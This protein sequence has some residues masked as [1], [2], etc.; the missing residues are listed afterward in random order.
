MMLASASAMAQTS[1][2]AST[3]VYDFTGYSA[4]VIFP[5]FKKALDEGRKYPTDRE[6][7]AAGIN[8]M[9][10]H[11]VRSHVRP[12]SIMLDHTKDIN[13]DVYPGRKLWMNIP[14]GIGKIQG[15]YPNVNVSDDTFTGWNYTNIFGSW[16]QPFFR[17]PAV[18]IDTAHKNGTDIYSGIMFFDTTGGRGQGSGDYLD[19]ISRKNA[20]GTFAYVEPIINALMYFGS[21]GINYN[22]EA[23]GYDNADVIKFHQALYKEAERQGFDNFHIGLYT[24]VSQLTNSNCEALLGKGGVKTADAFLNYSADDFSGY[25]S[26]SARIAENLFGTADGVYQGAWIVTMAR[27]WSRLV[28]DELAKKVGIVLWGEHAESRLHS[29]CQGSD[30]VNFHDNYQKLQDRFFAGGYRT[31]ALRPT[32]TNGAS[33]ISTDPSQDALRT[34][35]GLAEYIPERTA[36]NQNLPF[37]T[38]FNTGAGE[39]YNYK[40]KRT[41]AA[42]YNMGQQDIVPTYRWLIYDKGT[43]NATTEGIPEF[44]ATD[45][46]IG[47]TSLRLTNDKAVDVV[48][49]RTALTCSAGNPT[50]T[51]ALKSVNGPTEGTVSVIVKKQGS[52]EWIETPFDN[53][54]GT[55]W[56]EQQTALQGIAQGDVIEYVGLRTNGATDGLYIGELSLNDDVRVTP[57]GLTNV[58]AEVKEETTSTLSVKLCWDVD[59]EAQTRAAHNLLY[60]DEAGIDHFEVFYKNGPDGRISEVGRTTAWSTYLGNIPLTKSEQPYV[61]VR[62]ASIDGKTFGDIT[63]VSIPRANASTLPVTIKGEYPDSYLNFDSENYQAAQRS[64]WFKTLRAGVATASTPASSLPVLHTA[65]S[66][67]ADG[68]NYVL[69]EKGFKANQGDLVKMVWEANDASDGFRYCTGRA[70]ADWDGDY[71]FNG[72]EATYY[73]Y[74]DPIDVNNPYGTRYGGVYSGGNSKGDTQT[75]DERLARNAQLQLEVNDEVIWRLG[76]NKLG[77]PT[78]DFENPTE[79]T[80]QIPEDAVPGE[81]RVRIVYSDAWFPHPG[82]SGLT[83]K[84]FT[85]D[86]P[87]E[88]TGTNPYR[89]SVADTHDT[90][91]ADEPVIETATGIYDVNSGVSHAALSGRELRLENV[92]KAWIYTTDGRLVKFAKDADTVDLTDYAPATYI[93]RMQYGAVI[94]TQKISVQ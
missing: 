5:L 28:K 59:A 92:D 19:L 87:L 4:E 93:V 35:Q 32:P 17:A 63:W 36:I 62:P 40:G 71:N 74:A 75:R 25:I 47:G 52:D 39:R 70:Y 30:P 53:V 16:N 82:P 2:T 43:T 1:P 9:D 85:I 56:E 24:N 31:P 90:G 21:D 44:T 83:A 27:T 34:F 64:R 79:I 18:W 60:N 89:T 54:K 26:N 77:N 50:A 20:D 10:L 48:L 57:A 58:L 80:F 94:R 7:E 23:S 12:R 73:D 51:I 33:W 86:V 81:S 66:S 78:V 46:Y 55:T 15:G 45:S 42:W 37:T 88:I 49:Y 29:F 69:T 68:K 14:M 67:P 8:L 76:R 72:T 84:G 41:F 61:G 38:Y 11:F 91:I 65:T 6:L 22:W 13:Q 3:Q